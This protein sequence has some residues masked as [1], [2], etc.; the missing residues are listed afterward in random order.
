MGNFATSGQIVF[1]P[2]AAW[3][4]DGAQAYDPVIAS[5]HEI[6]HTM[7]LMDQI[8]LTIMGNPYNGTIMAGALRAGVHDANSDANSVYNPSAGDIADLQA[9]CTDCNI[10]A[11][12]V[13]APALAVLGFGAIR[14]R[15]A[16]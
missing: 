8:G 5:L 4:L 2:V 14:R 13:L 11:P 6:G 7:R 12:G 1:S 15:R 9:S 3:G 10:P 16:A